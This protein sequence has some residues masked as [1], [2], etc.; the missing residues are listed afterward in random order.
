MR[1]RGK[2]S[3]LQ[4]RD[5]FVSRSELKFMSLRSTSTA[6]MIMITNKMTLLR[7]K[8]MIKTSKVEQGK[9][10]IK[11]IL[12]EKIASR[13]Q[14][15]R[16]PER[17]IFFL[18]T[19]LL[20]WRQ[21]SSLR[22]PTRTPSSSMSTTLSFWKTETC[23]RKYTQRSRRARVTTIIQRSGLRTS[24]SMIKQWNSSNANSNGTI[25]NTLNRCRRLQT[26]REE[27]VHA[28]QEEVSYI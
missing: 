17:W 28:W 4:R 18:R 26:L 7:M 5:L 1:D 20:R 25:G 2:I 3:A 15:Q 11:I 8:I 12:W 16:S 9:A 13:L 21:G 19:P 6:W 23:A 24:L 14:R 22:S 10:P 27:R